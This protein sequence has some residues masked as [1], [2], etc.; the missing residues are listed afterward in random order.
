M[1]DCE[2]AYY[3][4]NIENYAMV[5][6]VSDTAPNLEARAWSR[7]EGNSDSVGPA[8]VRKRAD[9]VG[10]LPE[11]AHREGEIMLRLGHFVEGDPH[12]NEQK[13]GQSEQVSMT[14]PDPGRRPQMIGGHEYHAPTF[15]NDILAGR[16]PLIATVRRFSRA[17]V[18]AGAESGLNFP[19]RYKLDG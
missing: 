17:A 9:D 18:A 5:V 16:F 4:Y 10:A 19:A 15:F 7:G 11:I 14:C 2:F 3:D 12:V 13:Q 1:T 8:P 6:P